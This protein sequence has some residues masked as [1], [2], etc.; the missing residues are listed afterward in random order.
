MIR[1]PKTKNWSF[2]ILFYSLMANISVT[3]ADPDTYQITYLCLP[4]DSASMGIVNSTVGKTNFSADWK[5]LVSESSTQWKFKEF[6]E[7][8]WTS[9]TPF[10]HLWHYGY[11]DSLIHFSI[12]PSV[13]G[14]I[15]FKYDRGSYDPALADIYFGI[16]LVGSCSAIE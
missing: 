16:S 7:S 10:T 1:I 12:F 13:R 8:E 6:D 11:V 2:V 14:P 15:T 9:L 3:S 5:F 4:D